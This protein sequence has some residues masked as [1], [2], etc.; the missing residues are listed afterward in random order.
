MFEQEAEKYLQENKELL[1]IQ[2][3]DADI[4]KIFADGYKKGF[5]A[6]A[7][8]RLNITT[9][10]DNPIKSKDYMFEEEAE[11][12][13]EKIS[14]GIPLI[15]GGYAEMALELG[16]SGFKAGAEVGYNRAKEEMNE[17]GL[18]L[19]SDMDRTIEQNFALKKYIEEL[20]SQIEKMKCCENCKHHY[21]LYEELTCRIHKIDVDTCNSWEM[22]EK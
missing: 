14:K 15:K 3:E 2:L 18:A 20:K 11:D 7:K 4:K 1:E 12:F 19:Q 13:R 6:C 9:I 22:K 10:S 5:E 16:V 21:W 17:K 8:A